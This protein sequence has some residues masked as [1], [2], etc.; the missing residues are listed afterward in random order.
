MKSILNTLLALTVAT[1]CVSCS[2]G[3]QP[4]ATPTPGTA[5]SAPA[6]SPSGAP[7]PAASAPASAPGSRVAVGW[8]NDGSG[9]FSG[10]NPPTQWDE[11]KNI[12]IAWKTKIGGGSYSSPIVV[13]DRVLVTAEP[14][15]LVCLDAATGR[16]LW[17]QATGTDQLAQKPADEEKPPKAGAGNAAPT[18]VSDGK[19]VWA[20]FGNIVACY[21]L[22]GR[23][24][25]IK[26]VE[27]RPQKMEYGHSASPVL[28]GDKLILSI[29]CVLAV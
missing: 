1:L 19:M 12:G 26:S 20:Q 8:R 2:K 9:E 24:K 29:G 27:S 23:R 18:P 25:W 16:K 3:G 11:A 21:D 17:E 13:G 14:A 6:A 5:A 4:A 22:E 10:T 28:A 15:Q 7:A